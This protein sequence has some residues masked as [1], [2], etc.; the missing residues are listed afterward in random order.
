MNT[1]R[2]VYEGGVFRPIDAVDLPEHTRVE[3]EPRVV[4]FF[5]A[6]AMAQAFEILS[7]FY[8]TGQ[9]DLASRHDSYSSSPNKAS[10]ICGHAAVGDRGKRSEV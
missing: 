2:A 1:V 7:H 5:E 9:T 3:F 10:L 4:E 8:D 6:D